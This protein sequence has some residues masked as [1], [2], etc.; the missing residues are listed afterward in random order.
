MPF[1]IERND[2]ATMDVDAVVVAAN[3]RLL[4]DGG[5][6]LAVAEAAGYEQLQAACDAIGWCDTGSAVVTE[7]FDLPARFVVHAVGPFWHG[8]GS[9]EDELLFSAYKNALE[10]AIDHGATSIALPLIST[11]VR[12]FPPEVSL[13]IGREAIREFLDNHEDVDVTLVLYNRKAVAAALRSYGPVAEYIDDHYVD[14][15]RQTIAPR[16]DA[17]APTRFDSQRFN[18]SMPAGGHPGPAALQRKN[19]RGLG[20]LFTRK[21]RSRED[22]ASRQPEAR[23]KEERLPGPDDT[24]SWSCTPTVSADGWDADAGTAVFGGVS[25]ELQEA[26]EPI[27][28]EFADY[29]AAPMPAPSAPGAHLRE[30]A[31]RP[32]RRDL[33]ELLASLDEPFSTT[34]LALIDARGLLDSQVYKRANMSRQLFSKIRSDASYRP[35]KKTV[36]ALAVALELTLPETEDLLRRAGYALSRSSKADVIVEYYLRQGTYDI[37][38][39]NEALYAFDQPL[40]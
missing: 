28:C 11:G 40:L 2:L 34:L 36:L 8:G 6:A 10:C 22:D 21:Q 17:A 1:T 5:A 33:T 29:A 9:G 25:K 12:S 35:K 31:T 24:A 14:I 20:G 39:I 19:K 27:D 38:E 4:I 37:F 15:D 3:E 23:P 26:P 13:T 32:A 30:A 7:G 18:Q 16:R